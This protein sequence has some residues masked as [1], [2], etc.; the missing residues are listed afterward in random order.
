V[1]L[2]VTHEGTTDVK[3]VRKHALIQAYDLFMHPR[4]NIR[5]SQSKF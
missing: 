3:K 2:E 4:E 1:G 5:T